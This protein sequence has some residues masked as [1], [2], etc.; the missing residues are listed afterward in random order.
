MQ[1]SLK[2][3]KIIAYDI[4]EFIKDIVES[5]VKPFAVINFYLSYFFLLLT[6][7]LFILILYLFFF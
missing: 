3:I 5:G 7:E 6:K 1:F 4:D 2:L